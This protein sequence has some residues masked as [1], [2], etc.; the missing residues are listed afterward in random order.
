MNTP[1]GQIER[2][3]IVNFGD[4]SLSVWE[5]G[6]SAARNAGGY[7]GETAWKLAFKRDVFARIVQQLNRIGWTV[8]M[9][10]IDQHAVKHY[11]GGVARESAER[12]RFCTK[13]DL[14]ADLSISGRVVEF[15]MFQSVNCPTRADHDGRYEWDKEEVMPYV[16]RLE[17]ER[18]RRR[19]RDYLCNVFTGY[20]FRKPTLTSPNPDPLAYFNDKWDSEYD[21]LRGCHRFSRGPDGWPSD[22]ELG[23][24]YRKDKDGEI[25]RHGDVRW[26]R[27]SKGR[28]R[29]GRVYGGINGMWMM[30]YGPGRRDHA[31]ESANTF[32][33]YRPGETPPKVTPMDLRRKRLERLLQNAVAAMDFRRA[34]QLKD[35]LFPTG[36]LYVIWHKERNVYFD[37]MYSG[38]RKGI[39]DAGRYTLAELKPYLGS[40]LENDHLKAVLVS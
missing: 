25:L 19:I 4:A 27:D 31:H 16:L 21:K 36:Q 7:A 35:I 20:S 1:K 33:T 10:E 14:K 9:P 24:S 3:G 32:F 37:V 2:T 12:K 38:Y 40:T 6:I 8:T 39:S 22:K 34:Q 30:V 18:T 28:L 29:R 15:N 11:G 26:M 17:M 5:E 23:S 13:G